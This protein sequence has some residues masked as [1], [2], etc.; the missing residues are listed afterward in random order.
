MCLLDS[1]PPADS[2]MDLKSGVVG[3][4][5]FLRFPTDPLYVADRL[6]LRTALILK[7][8]YTVVLKCCF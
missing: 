1:V 8:G 3:R 2:L 5:G 7:L 4:M 6:S